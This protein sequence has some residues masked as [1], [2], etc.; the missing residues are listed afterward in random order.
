MR[1]FALFGLLLGCGDSPASA[2]SS[3]VDDPAAVPSEPAQPP[4]PTRVERTDAL[5]HFDSDELVS[6]TDI[7][8]IIDEP[9]GVSLEEESRL[10]EREES[11]LPANRAVRRLDQDCISATRRA[12]LATCVDQVTSETNTGGLY[13]YGMRRHYYA[14]VLVFETDAMMSDCLR[15]GGDWSVVERNSV[16]ALEAESRHLARERERLGRRL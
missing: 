7:F 1:H 11:S 16:A 12:P 15:R 6:C 14:F 8:Q 10:R 13:T 5:P 9:G 4:R 3:L 2:P